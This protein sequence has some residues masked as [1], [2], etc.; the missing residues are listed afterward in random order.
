M[1]GEP[2]PPPLVTRVESAEPPMVTLAATRPGPGFWGSVL[3]CVLF[4]TVLYGTTIFV[5]AATWLGSGLHKGD[6]G[7]FIKSELEQFKVPA[8]AE[9]GTMPESL[10]KSIVWGMFI[11]QVIGLCFVLL[12]IRVKLGECWTAKLAIRR[13]SMTLL[14]LA[15]LST[16]G[17][18]ILHGGWHELLH[19]IFNV[20]P[21]T[22]SGAMY[23]SMFSTWPAWF[24]VIVIGVCPGVLEELFCRGFLGRGLLAR[25]GFI[26]GVL[27]TSMF[28]GLLH[29]MPLYAIGTMFM[30]IAL[31]FTYIVTRSLW[32]PILIHAFNN[33]VTVLA[34]MGI[35]EL[36]AADQDA[37]GLD[38]RVYGLSAISVAFLF[39]ALW[40]GRLQRVSGDPAPYSTVESAEG[41]FQRLRP[42]LP[43]TL[44][45]IA[46]AVA[47]LY[48]VLA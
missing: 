40:T 7:G 38:A 39:A 33:S 35:I 8:P 11:G 29:V 20:K 16:P 36:S 27:L 24:A 43:A 22:A 46:A 28:F 1:S 17:L 37:A 3:W 48:L 4:L 9:P 19:I 31:H 13:P 42:N 26:G 34:T 10:G 15:L 5:T 45:G 12:V 32:T 23:K 30:G 18:M 44:L 2:E 21:D 41:E 25:Y 47:L 14:I 6:V